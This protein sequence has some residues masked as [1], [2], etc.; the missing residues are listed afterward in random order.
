PAARRQAL[1]NRR[2]HVGNPPYADRARTVQGDGVGATLPRP[3]RCGSCNAAKVPADSSLQSGCERYRYPGPCRR[4][5][6]AAVG[7]LAGAK[8]CG[9]PQAIVAALTSVLLIG[10]LLGS[11]SLWP[12][13]VCHGVLN[14]LGVLLGLAAAEGA[15]PAWLTPPP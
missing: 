7:G 15:L 13:I 2:G 10:L 8:R 3:A 4:H 12:C 1:R 6:P 11:R 5:R 14:A 9:L